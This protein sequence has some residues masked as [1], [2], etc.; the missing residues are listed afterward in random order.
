MVD[1]YLY[2]LYLCTMGTTVVSVLVNVQV[3]ILYMFCLF[4]I[5]WW[6]ILGIL[7]DLNGDMWAEVLDNLADTAI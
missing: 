6:S 1:V 2:N 3:C 7:C 5:Q 4:M